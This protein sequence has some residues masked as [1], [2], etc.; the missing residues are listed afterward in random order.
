VA[1]PSVTPGR[2]VDGRP[3]QS[4]LVRA[5]L[6]PERFRGGIAPSALVSSSPARVRRL[7]LCR[8]TTTGL[9]RGPQRLGVPM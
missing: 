9:L 6:V 1:S 5:V 3:L 4:C 7:L 2:L 8:Q